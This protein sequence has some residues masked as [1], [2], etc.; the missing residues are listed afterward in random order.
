MKML[1]CLNKTP[2]SDKHM[3][4]ISLDVLIAIQI[5]AVLNKLRNEIIF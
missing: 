4:N 2:G 1:F 5:K 3:N